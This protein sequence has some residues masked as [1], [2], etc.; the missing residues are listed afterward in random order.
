M[1]IVRTGPEEVAG[2]L[3]QTIREHTLGVMRAAWPTMMESIWLGT[4]LHWD[5]IV[6]LRFSTAADPD[7]GKV[8]IVTRWRVISWER[9]APRPPIRPTESEL[10]VDVRSAAWGWEHSPECLSP[11][12]VP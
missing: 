9:G 7:A 2:L 11:P 6:A 4:L 5:W 8:G 12:M 1:D 3:G 10:A